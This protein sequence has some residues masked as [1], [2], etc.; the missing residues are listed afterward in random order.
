MTLPGATYVHDR[1]YGWIT[2]RDLAELLETRGQPSLPQHCA[3]ESRKA[4]TQGDTGRVKV[5][6]LESDRGMER[7]GGGASVVAVAA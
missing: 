5:R 6:G 4:T 2:P 1:K 7:N 3:A